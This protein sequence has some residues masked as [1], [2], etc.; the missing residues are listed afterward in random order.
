MAK[1]WVYLFS[2]GTKEVDAHLYSSL[3]PDLVRRAFLEPL[4]RP[5][6]AAG[7]IDGKVGFVPFGTVTLLEG[8]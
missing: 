8:P 7:L 1:K 6:E 2:E 5:K 3:N 4:E